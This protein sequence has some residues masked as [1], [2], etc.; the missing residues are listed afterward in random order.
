MCGLPYKERDLPA[1]IYTRITPIVDYKG[2]YKCFS[3]SKMRQQRKQDGR[4]EGDHNQETQRTTSQAP[5]LLADLTDF[6][7]DF[8]RRCVIFLTTCG[9][10]KLATTFVFITTASSNACMPRSRSPGAFIFI[11]LIVALYSSL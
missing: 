7:D 3:E 6:E 10:A 1:K 5:L 9:G 4:S 2:G 11:Q 8:Q